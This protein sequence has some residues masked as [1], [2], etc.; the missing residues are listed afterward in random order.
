MLKEVLA[1]NI[2]SFTGLHIPDFVHS[3]NV[4]DVVF[5]DDF[6]VKVI[7]LFMLLLFMVAIINFTF[8][9]L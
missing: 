5:V 4:T 1:I 3:I 2:F 8:A 6:A 7:V 9:D